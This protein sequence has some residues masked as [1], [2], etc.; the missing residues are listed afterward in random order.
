MIRYENADVDDAAA[1]NHAEP[2]QPTV[3]ARTTDGPSDLIRMPV[4]PDGRLN[5]PRKG[6]SCETKDGPENQRCSE[7]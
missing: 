5:S 6:E 2:D 3:G 1:A 7:S 4:I